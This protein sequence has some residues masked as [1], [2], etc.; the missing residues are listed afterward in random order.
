MDDA[1]LQE[2]RQPQ[3]WQGEIR[4]VQGVWAADQLATLAL[5][6]H[7]PRCGANSPARALGPHLLKQLWDSC[8]LACLR[9]VVLDVSVRSAD[10]PSI[11]GRWS[12]VVRL[13]VSP[14]LLGLVGPVHVAHRETQMGRHTIDH[15][16][17]L[18]ETLC[19]EERSTTSWRDAVV[20]R[21]TGPRGLAWRGSE[22]CLIPHKNHMDVY[23]ANREWMMQRTHDGV[24]Y[25]V[26]VRSLGGV[27]VCD[28][29]GR[30]EGSGGG[31]GGGEA[32]AV[33]VQLPVYRYFGRLFK[34]SKA[35]PSQAVMVA[36]AGEEPGIALVVF[37]VAKTYATR[38]LQVVSTTRCGAVTPEWLN[39]FC[40]GDILVMRNRAG[41]TVFVFEATSLTQLTTQSV[42]Y[43]VQANGDTTQIY[44]E[45][46]AGVLTQVSGSLFSIYHKRTQVLDIWDCSDTSPS[47]ATTRK[48]LW[49]IKQVKNYKVISG[50]GLM[51]L[52]THKKQL[53]VIDGASGHCAATIEFLAP[54]FRENK[55]LMSLT[56]GGDDHD[57]PTPDALPPP[58]WLADIRVVQGV[59]ARDQVLALA[60]AGHSRRCGA[61]S[62]ARVLTPHLVAQLWDSWVLACLRPV[63]VEARLELAPAGGKSASCCVGLR[64]S[65]VLLGL[66][67]DAR[68]AQKTVRWSGEHRIT[69]CRFVGETLCCVERAAA[70]GPWDA[71]VVRRTGPLGAGG[72]RGREAC[73][74][75]RMNSMLRE[76]YS[77]NQEWWLQWINNGTTGYSLV[78]RS[79]GCVGVDDRDHDGDEGLPV[80]VVPIPDCWYFGKSFSFSKLNPSHA[81]MIVD[82]GEKGGIAIVVFDV[83]KTYSTKSLQVVSTTHCGTVTPEWLNNFH[84]GN[85]L[86]MRNRAGETVFVFEASSL[87]SYHTPSVV[88][89]VQ[90]NG[91]ATQ[92]YSEIGAGV[93]T[94]VSGSLF[95]IYH[96][97]T[98]VLDI[99]DCSDTS[100]ATTRK[101]LRSF[102]EGKKCI[103]GGGFQFIANKRQL[104]VID[105]ESGNNVVT[106]EFL[107]SELTNFTK[108][109]LLFPRIF[110]KTLVNTFS[111]I[112]ITSGAHILDLPQPVLTQIISYV[113]A[114]FSSSLRRVCHAFWEAVRED[115]TCEFI[116]LEML[117]RYGTT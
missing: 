87:A 80:V 15:C 22:R 39:D 105:A 31:G 47:A 64:L 94:Q 115:T 85:I 86:E 72:W 21:R 18:D 11:L 26:I 101:P 81:M 6:S 12:L 68:A 116:T 52:A 100:P 32:E 36:D 8:V 9:S 98:E 108:K 34:F 99:W 77:V 19:C 1:P 14:L 7:S 50:G 37:D 74:I 23:V 25:S 112:Q 4:V 78:V 43:A 3:V 117:V 17:W 51:F 2:Q 92:V 16:Q 55:T 89:A 70:A 113:P 90:P 44:S 102:N 46:G 82:G 5:A 93:L 76:P 67:G 42:V 41:D 88:Y 65:P 103:S 57:Q 28:G 96:K 60:L 66:V 45:I 84:L 35:I 13:R 104:Q 48:P 63:V 20:A 97:S 110:D 62:P 38:T 54:E 58:S 95:S 59:R 106:I 79:L 73:M 83:A 56:I 27:G 109:K 69:S 33:V 10:Q 49:S 53:Q 107:S 61:N 71:V 114:S 30:E 24:G 111:D 29:D 75:P 91:D 40:M